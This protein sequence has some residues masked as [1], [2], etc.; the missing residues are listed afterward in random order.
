MPGGKPDLTDGRRFS[1]PQ[2]F[3]GW[4]S[5]WLGMHGGG[6]GAFLHFVFLS[7]SL[8]KEGVQRRDS[9]SAKTRK[10]D[11]T[12]K[13]LG[14]IRGKG[15]LGGCNFDFGHGITSLANFRSLIFIGKRGERDGNHIMI[16]S[17]CV[18][19]LNK[20]SDTVI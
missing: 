9:P 17:T 1:W 7:L 15:W 3:V 13:T 16:D 14:R 5:L 11:I 4:G 18:R 8:C 10:S 6:C 20:F 2:W 19:C 12:R